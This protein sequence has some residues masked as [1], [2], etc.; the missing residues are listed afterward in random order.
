MRRQPTKYAH[1]PR[2][3]VGL[4]PIESESGEKIIAPSSIPAK[5]AAPINPVSNSDAHI[6]LKSSYQFHRWYL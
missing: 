6:T 1:R 2:M 3:C 5:T 4:H